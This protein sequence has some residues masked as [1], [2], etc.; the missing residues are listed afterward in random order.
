MYLSAYLSGWLLMHGFPTSG[1]PKHGF[2]LRWPV[3][4]LLPVARLIPVVSGV[5]SPVHSGVRHS[6]RNGVAAIPRPVAP[7]LPVGRCHRRGCLS[8]IDSGV[9]RPSVREA[10]LSG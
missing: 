8:R 7:V 3:G 5:L 9:L 1:F 4:A 6:V 10:V 2:P